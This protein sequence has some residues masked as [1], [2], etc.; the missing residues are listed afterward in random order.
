MN[1]NKGHKISK[2]YKTKDDC[3]LMPI[4]DLK[5]D[6]DIL[7]MFLTAT[8]SKNNNIEDIAITTAPIE[9]IESYKQDALE[10]TG[11]KISDIT[12]TA[13][14]LV[15]KLAAFVSENIAN[16]RKVN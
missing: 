12:V 3:L 2:I 1:I 13:G 14:T 6:K 10:Y 4:F 8:L 9:N 5:T 7:T 11:D 16:K 15:L